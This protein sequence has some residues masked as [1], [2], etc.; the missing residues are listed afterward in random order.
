MNPKCLKYSLLLALLPLLGAGQGGRLQENIC[1]TTNRSAYVANDTLRYS[2]Y[3]FDYQTIKPSA[4]RQT[5]YVHL[6]S[7]NKTSIQEQAVRVENGTARGYF[8]LDDSL[9]VG[10]YH[11]FAYTKAHLLYNPKEIFYTEIQILKNTSDYNFNTANPDSLRVQFFPE[12]GHLV[13]G[14]SGMVAFR[15]TNENGE[16]IAVD[17]IVLD[18]LGNE[19]TQFKEELEGM[20]RFWLKP[21]AEKQYF[22]KLN[23]RNKTHTFALPE[24]EKQG[25]VLSVV[26]A[27]QDSLITLR[28]QRRSSNKPSSTSVIRA[29]AAG[30]QY[31][32][33]PILARDLVVIK[34]PK[35]VFPTG[36]FSF[37]ITDDTSIVA[38]R[39]AIFHPIKP[40][41]VN[42]AANDSLENVQ[43]FL[44]LHAQFKDNIRPIIRGLSWCNQ[45]I[46][47]YLELLVLT[48]Q[49]RKPII[50]Q[51]SD[52]ESSPPIFGVVRFS[53]NKLAAGAVVTLSYLGQH[54]QRTFDQFVCNEKGEFTI[55][56]HSITDT[57]L[58]LLQA[59]IKKNQPLKIQLS[60]PQNVAILDY[61]L[62]KTATSTS[63]IANKAT[64]LKA[65]IGQTLDNNTKLKTIL[66]EEVVV[67]AKRNIDYINAVSHTIE[68]N[69]NGPNLATQTK[70]VFPNDAPDARSLLDLLRLKIPEIFPH[71]DVVTSNSGNTAIINCLAVSGGAAGFRAVEV[72]LNHCLVYDSANL[73]SYGADDIAALIYYTPTFDNSPVLA[74]ITKSSIPN[75]DYSKDVSYNTLL[76]RGFGFRIAE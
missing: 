18:N 27:A 13:N 40:T 53:D 42:Q 48:N 35:S 41:F 4:I 29:F 46:Y 2:I 36:V 52:V 44:W 73:A 67:K 62:P 76:T 31:F 1:L 54:K 49:R 20:G 61:F 8:V 72:F 66:M 68:S 6:V 19:I 10:N 12:S 45:Q 43:G 21:V 69:F 26:H 70:K 65:Q 56:N 63:N 15:A 30:Y 14:L 50:M 37:E 5:A 9:Q 24:A 38:R 74:I 71:R 75:Y 23:H 33:Q 34:V 3:L 39:L 58:V 7:N 17:G 55:K 16:G 51:D 64:E 59:K 60:Q 11:V 47:K 32:E 28:I 57:T 22:A 25:V